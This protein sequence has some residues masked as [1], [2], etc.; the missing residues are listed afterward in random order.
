VRNVLDISS[1]RPG[2]TILPTRF[3]D[4]LKVF[5][6]RSLLSRSA[7]EL[8]SYPLRVARQSRGL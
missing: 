8:A 5:N 3:H 6:G 4:E 2:A 1:S 7:G